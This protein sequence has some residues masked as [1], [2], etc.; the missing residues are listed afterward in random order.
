[1]TNGNAD[2][3]KYVCRCCTS[4]TSKKYSVRDDIDD[5]VRQELLLFFKGFKVKLPRLKCC[6]CNFRAEDKVL[7]MQHEI[8]NHSSYKPINW[9]ECE[10]CISMSKF[11]KKLMSHVRIELSSDDETLSVAIVHI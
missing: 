5:N 11:Y 1:M 3:K 2:D 10:K 8:E 9:Y 6:H 7:M 4:M